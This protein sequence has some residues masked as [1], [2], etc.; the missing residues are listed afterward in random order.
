MGVVWAPMPGL[1]QIR[2][3]AWL[4]CAPRPDTKISHPW[5]FAGKKGLF[6]S[7]KTTPGAVDTDTGEAFAG[8]TLSVPGSGGEFSLYVALWYK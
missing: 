3:V 4:G 2:R 7:I 6:Y 8:S 5:A 1:Q